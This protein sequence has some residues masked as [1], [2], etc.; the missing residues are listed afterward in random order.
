MNTVLEKEEEEEKREED[1]E[2]ILY[3]LDVKALFWGLKR[4]IAKF[5]KVDENVNNVIYMHC[6]CVVLR[7]VHRLCGC[8]LLPL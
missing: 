4:L 5:R 2:E 1:E 6:L 7:N 3:N 8:L